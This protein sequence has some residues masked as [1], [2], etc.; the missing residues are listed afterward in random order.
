M[1]D[2]FESSTD[3]DSLNWNVGGTFVWPFLNYGRIRNNIRVQDARLQQA[4]IAY[5]ETVIQAAR[6]VEDAMTGYIGALEKHQRSMPGRLVGVSIDTE[7]RPA[8]RLALQ[9]REKADPA[10]YGAVAV[11]LQRCIAE[12][13]AGTDQAPMMEG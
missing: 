1:V 7:E 10:A 5:R 4:L 2:H 6:E 3:S 13:V 11:A 8:L 12:E 9:T